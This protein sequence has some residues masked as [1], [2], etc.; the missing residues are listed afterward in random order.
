MDQLEDVGEDMLCTEEI[1]VAAK[2]AYD[3]LREH[4]A[5]TSLANFY[6]VSISKYSWLPKNFT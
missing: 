2:A 6:S 1:K 5:R 3:K 4:Y